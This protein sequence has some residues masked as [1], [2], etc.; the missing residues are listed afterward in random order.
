LVIFFDH[1]VL[2]GE[3]VVKL[4][5]LPMAD[6]RAEPYAMLREAGP[7]VEFDGGYLVTN[8]ELSEYVLKNPDI[9]SSRL[10]FETLGSPVP[11]IPNAFDPPEHTRYRRMLQPFF[12]PRSAQEGAE[13]ARDLTRE[14]IAGFS[15]RGRGDVVKEFAK[16]YSARTFMT[17]LGLPEQDGPALAAWRETIIGGV[18]L[19]GAGQAPPE[20]EAAA[21]QLFGY[22]GGYLARCREGGASGMLPEL[23]AD[24]SEDGLS[25]TEALGLCYMF[26]LSGIG[27]LADALS[28]V[29]A[30]LAV[31]P[32]LQRMIVEEPDVIPTLIEEC[33]R[34]DPPNINLPR[35]TTREV[36]VAGVSIPAGTVVGICQGPACRDSADLADP[37]VLDPRRDYNHLGFGAGIHRCIGIHAARVQMRVALEEW[38]RVIPSYSLAPGTSPQ[39][40]WPTGNVGLPTLEI[41]FPVPS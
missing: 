32:D 24:T 37:D 40:P 22:L 18:D 15:G 38:H 29:F 6:D 19:S 21:G 20:V 31:R 36:D 12:T 34:L 3:P 9:F 16:E 7:L 26:V 4:S 25:D 35:V 23:L 28:L 41:V 11:L 8:R 30:K 33:I 13:S 27:S 39:V 17:L 1:N 14:L 2:M 10:A 5:D